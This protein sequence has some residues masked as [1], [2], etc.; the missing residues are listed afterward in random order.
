MK[1]VQKL[2]G[3]WTLPEAGRYLGMSR[4]GAHKIKESGLF[5]IDDLRTIGDKPTFLVRTSAVV[6]LK[7]VREQ[8]AQETTDMERVLQ[9]LA[10]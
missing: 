1:G 7:K 5:H 8:T 10:D 9:S 3:W 6:L 4:Q 2:E